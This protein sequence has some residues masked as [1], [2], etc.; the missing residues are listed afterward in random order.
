LC[1]WLEKLVD[2]IY[3][4]SN[5]PPYETHFG[6]VGGYTERALSIFNAFEIYEG[7]PY[8]NLDIT[9]GVGADV[10]EQYNEKSFFLFIYGK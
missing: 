3:P 2:E 4:W 6:S 5:Q 7:A 8:S 10:K 9:H 1:S